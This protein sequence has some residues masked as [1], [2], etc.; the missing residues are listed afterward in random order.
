MKNWNRQELIELEKKLA[1]KI[2][3]IKKQIQTLPAYSRKKL[4]QKDRESFASVCL[5]AALIGITI[6]GSGWL[7]LAVSGTMLSL[8][9]VNSGLFFSLL[10]GSNGRTFY[11]IYL[12]LRDLFSSEKIKNQNRDFD[13][14]QHQ[15]LELEK[16]A[17]KKSV[18]TRNI[19]Y[20]LS[21]ALQSLPNK[22]IDEEN[23]QFLQ[24][25]L[26]EQILQ[27]IEKFGE[28]PAFKRREK[29]QQV[30]D[31]INEYWKYYMLG[32]MFAC[33]ILILFE[34]V[35]PVSILLLIPPTMALLF[36][37]IGL[38]IAFGPIT[39]SNI[40]RET[41]LLIRDLFSS[42]VIKAENKQLSQLEKAIDEL[43]DLESQQKQIAEVISSKLEP[44]NVLRQ[45]TE[46]NKVHS[47]EEL[48]KYSVEKKDTNF[49]Y[50]DMFQKAP[51]DHQ[52][53]T[54]ESLYLQQ[55]TM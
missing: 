10:L 7:V 11:D 27:L 35:C 20:Q 39:L 16:L 24:L 6:F 15:L 9:V 48:N 34:L 54:D 3:L 41:Y 2:T 26:K 19:N 44:A 23:T 8:V 52:F 55:M 1:K 51:A 33:M 47:S 25:S 17:A 50:G 40:V 43:I 49:K 21:K 31:T 45:N 22:F 36:I 53:G 14:T 32:I 38:V 37:P 46:V 42:T 29:D 18:L 12:G 30:S 5:F 13:Q 4:D 28:H